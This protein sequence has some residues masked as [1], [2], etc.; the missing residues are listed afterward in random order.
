LRRAIE[1]REYAKFIFS[2]NLSSALEDLAEIGAAYGLDREQVGNLQLNEIL[3]LRTT[4]RTDDEIAAHLCELADQGAKAKCVANACKLPPLITAE[5]DLDVFFI[6]A[7]RPNFIG[8][9]PVIADCLN[10]NKCSSDV[11]TDVSGKIILV[12]QADPG[13]D[14]IFSQGVA[15]LITLYGGA[16]SHMAI[17]AAEFGLPAA[18]GVGEQRYAE[19]AQARVLEVSPCDAVLRVVR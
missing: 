12:E 13:Y 2:R 8:S 17:R 4:S 7:D 19:L 15:G 11:S 1:G 5:S 9:T 10:L 6:G 16:N 3:A 18:I 14:W